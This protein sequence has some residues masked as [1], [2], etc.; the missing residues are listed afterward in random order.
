MPP[1]LK[2]TLSQGSPL[3]IWSP[4]YPYGAPIPLLC[5]IFT[6][7]ALGCPQGAAQP[8]KAEQGDVGR[9]PILSYSAHRIRGMGTP[10]ARQ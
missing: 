7:Q 8:P 2:D 1:I 4:R 6:C 10:L 3:P 5:C 9:T